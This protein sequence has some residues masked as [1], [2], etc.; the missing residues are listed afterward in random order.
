MEK[1]TFVVWK[2]A[3]DMCRIEARDIRKNI[4]QVS[5]GGCICDLET[6]LY[7]MSRTKHEIH[8]MGYDVVFE[9]VN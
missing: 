8:S 2:L 7:E 6:L 5:D 9:L 1:I 3:D 4:R